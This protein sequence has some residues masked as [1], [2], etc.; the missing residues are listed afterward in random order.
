MSHLRTRPIGAEM[1][2]EV[3]RLQVNTGQSTLRRRMMST[4]EPGLARFPIPDRKDSVAT[5]TWTKNARMHPLSPA[6]RVRHK[7]MWLGLTI[8]MLTFVMV[9]GDLLLDQWIGGHASARYIFGTACVIAGAC[10]ALF[11]IVATTGIAVS[12]AFSDEPS[13]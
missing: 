9:G 6:R 5:S 12:S 11:A 8:S 1:M 4:S 13:G 2:R 7:F 3:P 10:I